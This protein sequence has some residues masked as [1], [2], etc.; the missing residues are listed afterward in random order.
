MMRGLRR[1]G[2]EERR[3]EEKEMTNLM[4]TRGRNSGKKETL[5]F[6]VEK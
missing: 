3:K 4:R 5:T 1:G 2:D 6:G